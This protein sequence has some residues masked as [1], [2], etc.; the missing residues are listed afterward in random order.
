M[1]NYTGDLLI[2][3]DSTGNHDISFSCGNAEMTNGL[4]TYVI[5]AVFGEDCPANALVKNESEKMQSRFP[6]V[7]R[8]NVV[9]DKTVADGIQAIR[10]AL[11]PAVKE[12][13][14]NKVEVSGSIISAYGIA[15]EIKLHE[16]TG[17]VS[18]YIINWE[19]GELTAEFIK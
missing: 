3:E 8:R 6:E 17:N 5:L 7:I 19:R 15:W 4:E 18:R 2:K 11:A 1:T 9:N 13:I 12:R 14:V 16:L 10:Q